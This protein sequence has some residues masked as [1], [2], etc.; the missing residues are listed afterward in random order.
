MAEQLTKQDVDFLNEVS[1]DAPKEDVMAA[2][3]LAAEVAGINGGREVKVIYDNGEEE[4]IPVRNI[5]RIAA[6]EVKIDTPN[7]FTDTWRSTAEK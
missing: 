7:S 1:T 2:R 6:G 4:T 3:E 5:G